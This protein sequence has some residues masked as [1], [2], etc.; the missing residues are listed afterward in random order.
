LL[1]GSEFPEYGGSEFPERTAIAASQ[2]YFISNT[3][4]DNFKDGKIVD[5]AKLVPI[6][7]SVVDLESLKK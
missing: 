4:V 7:I 3:G 6:K 1:N 2:F 5:P